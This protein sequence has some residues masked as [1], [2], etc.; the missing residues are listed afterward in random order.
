MSCR[1]HRSASYAAPEVWS[2]RSPVHP[3]DEQDRP[4]STSADG[5]SAP[6]DPGR[7]ALSRRNPWREGSARRCDMGSNA[8][9]LPAVVIGIG[10]VIVGALNLLIQWSG[11][12][13][14]LDVGDAWPLF[15]IVPG[16][17]LFGLAFAVEP[18]T[19]HR[20]RHP[21]RHHHVDRARPVDPA[22]DRALRQLGVRLGARRPRRRRDRDA[23]LRVATGS[24]QFVRPGLYLSAIAVALFA[25]GAWYFEPVLTEGREPIELAA[26]WPILIIIVGVLP[27]V[28]GPPRA[29][30]SGAGPPRVRSG[31]A[32]CAGQR[33]LGG[34]RLPGAVS[35]RMSV[36]RPRI[37]RIRLS[38][39]RS[40][41]RS[42]RI[43]TSQLRR[44][45]SAPLSR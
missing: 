39:H 21:G 34:L 26:L 25:I 18:P 32:A 6:A 44:A 27:P 16:V 23:D 35:A 1:S 29:A 12:G 30:T 3:N 42:C 8:R 24:K 2:P 9:P 31:W 40:T 13:A 33:G 10:L 14:N 37:P 4:E 20:I 22:G 5:T 11:L 28:L 45:P 43:R 41:R 38:G 7:S 36:N 15:V 19:G 17:V